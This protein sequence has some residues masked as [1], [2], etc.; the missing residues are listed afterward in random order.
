MKKKHFSFI[1]FLILVF[2]FQFSLAQAQWVEISS[3]VPAGLPNGYFHDVH[4]IGNECWITYIDY[5]MTNG[6]ILYSDDGG[7][8]FLEQIIP[9]I[10]YVIEMVNSEIGFVGCFSGNIYYTSDGGDG[11][12]KISGSLGDYVFGIT[13][14]EDPLIGHAC[15]K[16]GWIAKFD[17]I[18]VLSLKKPIGTWFNI[19]DL[20]DIDFPSDTTEGW[21]CG[22]YGTVGHYSIGEWDS[23]IVPQC[24]TYYGI[25]FLK[26][27]QEGW[28]S[29]A[30]GNIM[31]P[32]IIN[33][34]D[35]VNWDGQ[36]H[37][38]IDQYMYDIFFL[39]ENVGWNVGHYILASSNG[40]V[41]WDKDAENF[42][43]S[44]NAVHA[45]AETAV[46][47]V[48]NHKRILKKDL[49]IS[50]EEIDDNFS[51]E[52]YPNP[53]VNTLCVQFE[54]NDQLSPGSQLEIELFNSAGSKMDRIILEYNLPGNSSI[55]I[56]MSK[57]PSGL[58]YLKVSSGQY[59]GN[60]KIVKI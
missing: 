28:C 27:S 59:S 26:G 57:Y 52:V 54:L 15:G 47:I 2:A 55:N 12:N 23:L 32:V 19:V 44:W 18:Q 33:T 37:P 60:K 43:G 13:A 49:E 11:W 7:N 40:G 3:N 9:D 51:F 24:D 50:I 30:Q 46:Y 42:P 17:T 56:D 31:T 10:P 41:T 48:G 53:C 16:D 29:G 6:L 35:G 22:S 14:L 34:N 58:Y 1:S 45:S 20:Y 8:S 38:L 4:V 21:V 39:N 25:C 36:P 5:G